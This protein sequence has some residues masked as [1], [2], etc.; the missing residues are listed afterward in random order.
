MGLV[1]QMETPI[2]VSNSKLDK[3]EIGI[4]LT[5][6]K[7]STFKGEDLEKVYNMVVKLQNQIKNV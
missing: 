6:I 5:L 3:V 2:G 4:I 1:K 7:Q